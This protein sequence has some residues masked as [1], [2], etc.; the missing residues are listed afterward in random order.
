MATRVLWWR[1]GV[2]RRAVTR[3]LWWWHQHRPWPVRRRVFRLPPHAVTTEE[4]ATRLVIQ[5]APHSLDDAAWA[6][7]SF[8]HHLDLPGERLGLTLYVDTAD[9]GILAQAAARW[10]W[11]FPGAEVLGTPQPVERLAGRAPAVAAFAQVHPTGRKLA[12]VLDAQE[13]ASILFVD[14]DVL[15]F[16]FPA[17][18]A[19]SMRRGGPARYNLEDGELNGDPRLVAHAH[20]E[21]W[22]APAGLNSGLLF[23]PRGA[24]AVS[25]AERLLASGE[26]DPGSWFVEQTALALLLTAAGAEPLPG[27]RYVVSTQ[28]QFYGDPDRDYEKIVTRHFTTPVRHL[29]YAR[30]MPR[31][32]R[33]WREKS[34]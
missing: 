15:L 13:R 5:A 2:V 18:L 22:P 16:R 1:H 7:Y 32:W 24:L 19:E 29:M 31:L 3:P 25:D 14:S 8:L 10:Q 11:L 6:A 30:G 23:I 26:F 34:P 21:G 12:A 9:P 33:Q 27:A 20:R 28:G 4:T 17:E